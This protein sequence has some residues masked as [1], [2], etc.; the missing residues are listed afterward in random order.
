MK[1][2]FLIDGMALIY[3]SYYAF[4]NNPLS[5]SKGFP[6]SA[7]Y[8]FLTSI[9]K[10]LNEEKPDYISIALDAQKPTFRHE[11]FSNYKANRKK[12][13]D[14]LRLQIPEIT[15]IISKSKISLLINEG[16]EADDIIATVV[17]KNKKEELSTYIVTGDKDIMQL[18]DDKT[19]VYNPGN[20]FSGPII[21]DKEKVCKKWN[22]SPDKICD[23]LSIMG[24]ASDNIPGVKGIG[25]KT[26]S[27]LINDFGG[28]Q[29]ILGKVDDI[30]NNR[31]KELIKNQVED[32]RMAT[33][34]VKLKK[35]VPVEF[36][37]D[38]MNVDNVKFE[39]IEEDL[40]KYEMPSL[41]ESSGINTRTVDTIDTVSKKYQLVIN[42]NQFSVLKEDFLKYKIISFDLETTDINP[43][44]ANIVGISFSFSHHEA[45]YI[46]IL[47]PDDV[48]GYELDRD[49]V[50]SELKEIWE[51][52]SLYFVGQNIKYDSIILSR[53][54]IDVENIAFDTMLA[55]HLIN[56]IK[57]TYKLDDLSLEYLNYKKIN[58]EALI[59]YKGNQINMSEVSVHDVKDY[60][61]EDA[62]VAFQLYDKLKEILKEKK[63]SKLF[64]DIEVPFIKVLINI[65]KEGLFVDLDV[66]KT[67]SVKIREKIKLILKNIYELSEK[68]FNVNSPQ[69]LAEVLFDDLKLKQIKKRSTAV[70]VLE[71][72]KNDHPLPEIILEYR[73]LNKL[74]TTY[75]Q[76]IP[77]FLNTDTDRIHTSF[78]QTVASTGRL[79]STKPNFQNIPI[80]TDIGKEIRRGFKAQK[81]GWKLI[82]ADYSQIEL[83]IMA[84]FSQEQALISAFKNNEDV[85]SKT[86]SLVYDV[87]IDLVTPTQRRQAKIVN[88]G[89]MY[90]AGPFRMSQELNINMKKAKQIIE[91]YFS[92]YSMVK[93]FIDTTLENA[94]KTGYVE[95]YFGRKRNTV[96]LNSSNANIVNAEKRAAINMP[97]QG[98]ASELIKIAMININQSLQNKNLRSKMVLQVH[99]ELLFEVPP[100]EEELMLKLIKDK[101]ENSIKLSIPIE[102]DCK[103]GSN[104]YEIH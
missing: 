49:E 92:T 18:V 44:K 83:R 76:G 59:G 32:I 9:F 82:S 26:A 87:H 19:F 85:H 48:Q 25:P 79:S 15:K 78:N 68:E 57:S 5:T 91:N 6:T 47:F 13:P 21:Y 31:I 40:K 90:G 29:E 39:N 88:Y 81:D 75:L 74:Q 28:A 99:D 93:D 64:N 24:D 97:I 98:T 77:K 55:A 70:E 72:L 89:I 50:L 41:L 16:Y 36:D 58:I 67:L 69:Q 63:L 100:D 95:T 33:E 53:I 96:N 1:K 17:E 42:K 8:G 34:L 11:I 12:M 102:V 61:C 71:F 51:N 45:Y 23:L 104:W 62:D 2:L 3:R 84:H 86:A 65:E 22:V 14:D 56:P 52:P 7:I 10:I 4:I 60:A 35:D 66:L 27:K 20:K 43:L 80:R 103:S 37:I 38:S 73:H 46:P 54:G 101:M 30:A 94:R